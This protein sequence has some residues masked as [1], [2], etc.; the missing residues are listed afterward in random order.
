MNLK[1]FPNK[2]QLAGDLVGRIK[3]IISNCISEFGD[4]RVLLSG[5]ST[6]QFI[7]ELLAKEDLDWNKVYIGLVDEIFVAVDSQFSNERLIRQCLSNVSNANLKIIGMVYMPD[8][9]NK[10]LS[11]AQKSYQIFAERIDYVLLGMG[12]DGH[13]ASLFPNDSNSLGS[14]NSNSIELLITHAPTHPTQR[15]S[16]SKQM[17]LNATYIDLLILGQKKFSVLEKSHVN[18]LPI[19][20]FTEKQNETTTFYTQ[21]T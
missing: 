16:C 9:E 18:V 7:Y 19:S 14:L 11:M 17:L 6:P 15:I 12:E 8:D 10:N 13:T 4:A 20:Y 5:G 21:E 3:R 2:K 1:T